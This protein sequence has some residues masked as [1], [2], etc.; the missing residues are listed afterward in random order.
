MSQLE[1]TFLNCIFFVI[2]LKNLN[3]HFIGGLLNIDCVVV[4][5]LFTVHFI[6]RIELVE[7]V[8]LTEE[9]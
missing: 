1:I 9:S 4:K 8:K 7:W 3:A 2:L 5:I 6:T